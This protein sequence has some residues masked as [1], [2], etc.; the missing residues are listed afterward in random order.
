MPE[1]S[2]IV[3]TYNRLKLLPRA[4]KSVELQ[5]YSDWELIV[6]DDGSDDGTPE[7]LRGYKARWKHPQP[8]EII[9]IVNQGISSARNVGASFATSEWLAFLDS[10][11]E[12]LP[13][14]LQIQS[15]LRDQFQLI[16]SEEIW[17][18]NGVRVNSLAKHAKG[19]GNQ[20]L[21]CVDLCC[22]G[23][24]TVL[25]HQPLFAELGGFDE[26]FP[27]CEDYELWLKACAGREVGFVSEPLI[28]KHGG[29]ADQLSTRF[30]SMD[31]WRVKA[32][33]PWLSHPRLS[34]SDR[35]YI[36]RSILHRS[37]VLLKGASKRK[38]SDLN[39]LEVE[40]WRSLALDI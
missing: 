23:P 9:S 22:I 34:L 35:D 11:D 12:W 26:R 30:H 15:Q 16:H 33:I 10:D 28:L 13:E 32:L 1:I 19:G 38:D 5:H 40:S 24:S 29:H 27:V 18:R 17:I 21:R 2:V 31:Y 7:W 39:R 25:M 4:L 37:E 20:F 6:V 8:L 14:K 3:P 36:R